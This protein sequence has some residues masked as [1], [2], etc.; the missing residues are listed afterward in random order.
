MQHL[1]PAKGS[2]IHF[3]DKLA[4]LLINVWLNLNQNAMG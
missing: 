1:L 3:V 4:V 2:Y